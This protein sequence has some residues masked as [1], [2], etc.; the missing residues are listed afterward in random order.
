MAIPQKN[1]LNKSQNGT[2]CLEKRIFQCFLQKVSSKTNFLFLQ[3]QIFHSNICLSFHK[4]KRKHK[5]KT[6]FKEAQKSIFKQLFKSPHPLSQAPMQ[7]ILQ[8]NFYQDFSGYFYET[9]KNKSHK[10]SQTFSKFFSLNIS[11]VIMQSQTITLVKRPS[12]HMALPNSTR[13][14]NLTTKLSAEKCTGKSFSSR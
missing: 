12:P 6:T 2:A 8:K 11:S 7:N 4:K 9:P 14:T 13:L 5:P 3:K 10:F 1:F